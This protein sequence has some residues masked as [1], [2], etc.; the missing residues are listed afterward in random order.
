MRKVAVTG[1]GGH[2]GY[3]LCA[4]LTRA[5]V[6]THGL[7]H[8]TNPGLQALG[9]HVFKG[10]ITDREVLAR[11][12]E[13]VTCVFHLAAHIALSNKQKGAIFQTNLEGT[14]TVLH[15]CQA[16]G[17]SR[18]VHCSTIHV[19]DPQPD[20]MPL[21]ETRPYYRRSTLAY[22]Q[23][24]LAAEEL[25]LSCNDRGP[26]IVV[27]NPTAI[28]GPEDHGPSIVGKGLLGIYH[29]TIPMLLPYGY[30]WVDVR[31][32]AQGMI[33]AAQKGQDR[34]RYIL[35]GQFCSLPDMSD[36]IRKI[37]GKKTTSAVC[38]PALAYLSV[39]FMTAW[40]NWTGQEPL[41]TKAALDIVRDAPRQVSH[42]KAVR[43]LGFT[44]RPLKETV[45]ET[46]Q[47]YKEN[48]LLS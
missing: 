13:G 5:G 24:K 14:R 25:L 6:T 39:P 48:G 36:M 28:L 3:V 30:N 29:R 22:E 35:S 37:T 10:D 38:P 32:V 41:Y 17:V 46:F 33:L 23:S 34:S 16:A 31:D 20:N 2:L 11:L 21:D 15:A 44:A 27:V 8:R 19:F 18:L 47:W 1:A 7:I 43:E 42:A 40:A 12:F 4:A 9:V 26:E 45:T